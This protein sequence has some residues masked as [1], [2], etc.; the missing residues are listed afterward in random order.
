MQNK[1][2]IFILL[3]IFSIAALLF[4]ALGCSQQGISDTSLE[5]KDATEESKDTIEGKYTY[6]DFSD[7]NLCGDCHQDIYQEWQQSLMAQSFIHEWDD[8][9]YFQLALPHAQKLDKVAGVKSGCI[10][11][12]GPLA[13]LSGD[14]PPSPPSAETKVNEGVSCDVCHFI[15]GSSET[16]PFNFSFTMDVGEIKYGPRDDA[17]SVYHETQYSDFIVSSEHCA[18]CH[19]EQSPYGAWVKETYREW[20]ASSFYDEGELCQDCH[21][22][23]I[24]G[25]S[26][27]KLDS[28]GGSSRLSKGGK[29]RSDIAHHTF[30]GAHSIEMLDGVVKISLSAEKQ[31][32][33]AGESIAIEAELYNELCGHYFPSGSSEERMLW[34]EVWAI[35]TTGNSYHIPVTSKGFK[36]EEYTIAD[37]EA[38]AYSD[39]G[40]IM[41]IADFGGLSRDGNI[42]DG[43][44]IF[45]RPFFNPDGE[46]TICQW[47]TESNTLVDYRFAPG[48]TKTE[49]YNWRVP[50]GIALGTL[51]I[52]A[53]LYYSLI[54]TSIGEFFELPET[55]YEAMMVE[56]QSFYLVIN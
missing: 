52:K 43:A 54:P 28:N 22:E 26:A 27:V 5:S 32:A 6:N 47:Y 39:I 40:E 33:S 18:T 41:E 20:Q 8:V 38:I 2:L 10:A 29:Y 49:M 55:E 16:I 37:S 31:Q 53:T 13:Y 3:S 1:R 7:P 19:D 9:E 56:S 30:L 42:P 17:V 44:R 14:I 50:E 36:G 48:E 25:Q 24:A 4:A 11:C 23:Y 21:M 45:R 34:L 15:T 12:H 51:T 46:M 35:D